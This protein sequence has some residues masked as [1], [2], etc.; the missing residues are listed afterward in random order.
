MNFATFLEMRAR[1]TPAATALVDSRCRFTW[2]ELDEVVNRFSNL[3]LADG[4]K[5]GD[6]LA[7]Y[8]PNRAEA[9]I[10]ILAAMKTGVVAVPLNWRLTGADLERVLNHCKPSHVIVPSERAA[11]VRA[12]GRRVFELGNAQFSGSFWTA[13]RDMSPSARARPCQS[14]EVAN[15]L[16]TSGTMSFPKAAIHTHGM[17]VSVAATMADAFR[18]SSADVALAVSPLFHTSGFSVFSNA[19]FA[20]CPLI[21]QEKWDLAEF[22]ALIETERVTFMHL[23]TTLV[24][25]IVKAPPEQLKRDTSSMRLTWGGGHNVDHRMFE[26]FEQ[27]VGGVFVQGY[28]RTEGG[29]TYNPADRATRRFDAHGFPNANSSLVA[30]MDPETAQPVADGEHGEIVVRGDGV[31][32]GYW[33]EDGIHPIPDLNGWQRTGDRGYFDD[34]GSMHFLGRFDSMIKTG[35]ENVYPSE[36]EAVLL[37]LPSV[38]NAMVL[39]VPDD[40]LGQRIGAVIVPAD[41]RVSAADIDR[42]C[43]AS[44]PGFKIPRAIAFVTEL[45]LLGNQKVD[46]AECRELLMK[47]IAN[48][49]AT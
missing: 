37:A 20:G 48:T 18:L 1:G 42:A 31:S 38:K 35:G 13:V 28:S 26:E 47:A 29:L 12:V 17:R 16:Y 3:L 22:L 45:P 24:V 10:A 30:I 7:I 39:G 41:S 25:D 40:R 44:L 6:R 33:K 32:P 4:A 8:S 15:L 27:R 36:V 21:L 19:L 14:K 9:V 46:L 5:S 23:I 2:A 34:R 43:R 49:A 11:S